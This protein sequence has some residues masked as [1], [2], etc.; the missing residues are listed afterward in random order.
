MMAIRMVAFALIVGVLF[1][2][3]M[4]GRHLHQPPESI[5]IGGVI[6]VAGKC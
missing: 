2:T 1:A 4:I 5:K 3:T 6:C